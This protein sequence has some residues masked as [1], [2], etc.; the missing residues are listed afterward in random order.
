M[1]TSRTQENGLCIRP[2]SRQPIGH[3]IFFHAYTLVKNTMTFMRRFT[4]NNIYTREEN[5]QLILDT[6]NCPPSQHI[7]TPNRVNT[8]V[9]QH[10]L[11]IMLS[12]VQAIAVLVSVAAASP[13]ASRQIAIPSEWSWHVTGSEMGCSRG[14]CSYNFNV[15]VP[16]VPGQIAGVK[17][18]CYG[19]EDGY[20][21][22]EP[23]V[24]IPHN[25]AFAR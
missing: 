7:S 3:H 13:L 19:R 18:Y 14:G 10:Q 21:A 17:A 8:N 5:L 9:Y 20:D 12:F 25:L 11:I 22:G 2:Q 16:A 23:L 24:P 1:E 4:L 15:T 6:N